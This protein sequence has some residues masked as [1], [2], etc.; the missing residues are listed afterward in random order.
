MDV[1]LLYYE[2]TDQV[3]QRVGLERPSVHPYGVFGTADGR[4]VLIS[5][6]NERERAR[7]YGVVLGEP[8][9]PPWKIRVNAL[10]PVMGV[11]GL[12]E[13]LVGV[14]DTPENQT[15]VIAT[16]P[17]GRMCEPEDMANAALWLAS[18]E[19]EFIT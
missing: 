17:L 19:A 16:I 15:R 6:Q 4:P 3:P 7:C 1:P 13:A 14:L 2:G 8:D 12:L 11:T 10:C 5:I 18:D 9:S